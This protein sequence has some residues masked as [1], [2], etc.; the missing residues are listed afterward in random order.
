MFQLILVN[1]KVYR[2]M[3]WTNKPFVDHFDD[4]AIYD[5]NPTLEFVDDNGE[6][7][8]IDRVD[9]HKYIAHDVHLE[10]DPR[11]NSHE[12]KFT[13]C[14]TDG[15]VAVLSNNYHEFI[16]FLYSIWPL[17]D[18]LVENNEFDL[19]LE[20]RKRF[21]FTMAVMNDRSCDIRPMV[22][23][24]DVF[25]LADD[26]KNYKTVAD[27]IIAE[28]I[29]NH[30]NTRVSQ[31]FHWLPSSEFDRSIFDY[32]H[33]LYHAIK[34]NDFHQVNIFIGFFTDNNRLFMSTNNDLIYKVYTEECSH[35]FNSELRIKPIYEGQSH[36]INEIINNVDIVETFDGYDIGRLFASVSH[37]GIRLVYEHEQEREPIFEEEITVE[38]LFLNK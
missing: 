8:K 37:D 35:V 34:L 6:S 7:I 23:K 20:L 14:T 38:Q 33:D 19:Y 21:I 9:P 1:D 16:L 22:D 10:R 12:C 24:Y 13:I 3:K 25:F 28:Q 31:M 30:N 4:D 17:S 27:I 18:S 36:V 5:I 26:T 29:H 32:A 15:Y 11:D 2:D